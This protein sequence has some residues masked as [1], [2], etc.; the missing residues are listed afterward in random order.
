MLDNLK[1]DDPIDNW[2]Q[3]SDGK[4]A[5]GNLMMLARNFLV[6][7]GKATIKQGVVVK[8]LTL[9]AFFYVFVLSWIILR[10]NNLKRIFIIIIA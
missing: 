4:Y 10:N 9:I 6:P 7:Y 3:Y 2:G 1:E 5:F 8:R